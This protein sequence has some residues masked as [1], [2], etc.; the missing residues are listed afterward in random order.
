MKV[1]M[2]TDLCTSLKATEDLVPASCRK[3]GNESLFYLALGME[4]RMLF[5]FATL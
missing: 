2:L 5:W 4:Y 1:V 3:I